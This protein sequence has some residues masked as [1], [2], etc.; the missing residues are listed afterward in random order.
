MNSTQRSATAGEIQTVLR[1]WGGYHGVYVPEFTYGDKR[2]DVVIIDT[3]KRWIRGFE[4]KVS[5]SDFLRDEKWQ[6]YT[7]FCS[8]LTI[9]CPEGLI[10]RDEVQPPFGLLY[11][12]PY[13]DFKWIRKPKR[14]QHRSGLAWLY[15][16]V[17]VIEKELP[18]MAIEVERMRHRIVG[19]QA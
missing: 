8:S 1:Q 3:G 17:R 18:R 2:I 5:R 15:T 13:G 11:V 4:I 6:S 14:F 10:G 7:E 9:V 16:Y 12:M 19:V